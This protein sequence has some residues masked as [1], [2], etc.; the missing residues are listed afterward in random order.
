MN[1]YYREPLVNNPAEIREYIQHIDT[2][3][4]NQFLFENY[5]QFYEVIEDCS[6]GSRYL[7]DRFFSI[8]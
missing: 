3:I 4:F 8:Q 1:E 6:Q 7:S 2:S 5:V